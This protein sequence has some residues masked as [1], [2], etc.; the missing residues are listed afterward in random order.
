MR[1][2]IGDGTYGTHPSMMAV[3]GRETVPAISPRK[4]AHIRKST[5]FIYRN[6]AIATCKR[7]VRSNRHHWSGH[8]RRRLAKAQT[9]RIKRLFEHQVNEYMVGLPS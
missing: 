2:L 7:L 8:H 3:I 9:H 4:G 6:A 5:V 1:A